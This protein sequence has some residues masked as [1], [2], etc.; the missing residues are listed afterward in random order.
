MDAA[1]D[2]VWALVEQEKRVS[3]N[4]SGGTP[5]GARALALL[6]HSDS[7]RAGENGRP[8]CHGFAQLF[9]PFCMYEFQNRGERLR[10]YAS[11]FRQPIAI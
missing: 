1:L 9:E 11:G 5:V 10:D 2:P 8:K 4:A 6:L 3:S 7:G